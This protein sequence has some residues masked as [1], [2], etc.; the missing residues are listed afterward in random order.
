MST[1][2]LGTSEATFGIPDVAFLFCWVAAITIAAIPLAAT[3]RAG[4]IQTRDP[5]QH[6]F[7]QSFTDL[8]EELDIAEQEDKLG[9]LLF[10]EMD[11]CPY[12]AKMR[13]TVLNQ[14]VV[15][16]WYRKYFRSISINVELVTEATDFVGNETTEK[17]LAID[18]G[19]FSTP[20]II[21]FDRRGNE[22]YRHNRM[23]ESGED[24]IDL[25]LGVL[26]AQPSP[27][28]D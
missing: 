20:T 12:C 18:Y 15:Q 27:E 22:V 2:G 1:V 6:F 8:R 19:V 5:D 14:P 4:E 24:L 10:F 25:G 21:F 17:Q 9:L 13:R 23:I 16:D 11:G 7:E 28:N 26:L 3:V